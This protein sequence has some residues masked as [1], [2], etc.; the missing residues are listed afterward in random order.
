MFCILFI[1]GNQT[2]QKFLVPNKEIKNLEKSKYFYVNLEED[3]WKDKFEI[4]F[5]KFVLLF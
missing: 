3:F 4:N 1:L 2:N 5:K